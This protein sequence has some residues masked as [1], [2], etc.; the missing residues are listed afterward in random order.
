MNIYCMTVKIQHP[1]NIKI[2]IYL[3]LFLVTKRAYA[4]EEHQMN[5]VST[6]FPYFLPRD[7]N[8]S[9]SLL[10]NL[11]LDSPRHTSN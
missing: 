8:A 11:F 6:Q 9:K 5:K 2:C 10:V 4:Y 7:F 3:K 1:L